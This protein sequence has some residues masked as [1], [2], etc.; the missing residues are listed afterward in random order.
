MLLST[1]ARITD[2]ER[3]SCRQA[4]LIGKLR[5]ECRQVNG[6]LDQLS[7]KYREEIGRLGQHNE[8]LAIQ[9][10]RCG[11]EN[12]Y[13][14]RARA[15]FENFWREFLLLFEPGFHRLLAD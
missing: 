2:L 4:G 11:S 15:L 3:I 6:E 8:E 14:T 1:E 7:R 13:A 10:D 5:D 12:F 9:A